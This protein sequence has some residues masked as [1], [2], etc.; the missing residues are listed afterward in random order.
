MTKKVDIKTIRFMLH[1]AL[2]A[3]RIAVRRELDRIN[4]RSGETWPEEKVQKKLASLQK[5]L[6]KS[7][8]KRV[9][10]EK[11]LPKLTYNPDL[12]IT[13]KKEEII[14][15]I[16]K[17]RV[18]IISGE[19]GSGKTTQIPKFCLSAG[20]GIDGIIGCTQPRR[21]AATTVAARIAEELESLLG[22]AVGYKIRFRDRT[23]KR[24]YIKLMTDGILLTEAQADRRLNLYDTIIVDEAH[25]RSLNIDFILGLLRTLIRKRKDLKVIITSATI[26]T[27]KFS[28]AFDSA[29]VIE[30]SG[31]MYPVD[32]R[33]F[34]PEQKSEQS[35]DSTYI[36][37]AI[38]A[39]DKVMKEGRT[40][41]ILV[42]MPTEQDIRET[43]DLIEGRAYKGTVVFPLFARLSSAQQSRV[44]SNLPGRK[45]IVSTNIAETSITIPGI[46]YVI[47]TGLARISRYTP[48]SRTTSL[49][50]TAISRSS[51][52]QRMGR[53]GRVE[54]GVCIRLYSEDDYL[55]RPIFTPPEVLRAN[56]AEVILRMIAL[57]LGDVA[58]FPFIDRPPQ[59]SIADGFNLLTELGSI[60]PTPGKKG[61][62]KGVLF[63]LSEKGKL[64]ARM[65][66]DPRLSRM[67]IEARQ[68][69]CVDEILII[70]SALSIRDPRERPAERTKEADEAHKT[71]EDPLS[72]FI[73]L[74]NIWKRY[75]TIRKMEKKTRRIKKFCISH[76]L[77]FRRM[78]E[79]VDLH[80][81]LSSIFNEYV[82]GMASGALSAGKNCKSEK[83][84]R[85]KSG[86]KKKK[87]SRQEIY[88]E[89]YSAMHRSV[90]SG[91]LSNIAMKKEKNLF[92]STKGR[93]V[94][95]FPGSALFNKAGNWIVAAEMVE[96]S[97][98][99]ARIVADI[100]S[101]WLES[102][103][104]DQCKY[105]YLHPHWEKNRGEVIASEQVSLYGL[106]IVPERPVSYGRINPDEASEIFIREGLVPGDMKEKFPFLDH[107]LALVGN[108][109]DSEDRIRKRDIL[110]SDEEMFLFYRDRLDKVFDVRTLARVLRKKGKDA[111][112]WMKKDDLMRY[113]PDQEELSLYPGTVDLGGKNYAC[114]YVFNPEK[115]D[116]G[117]TISIPAPDASTVPIDSVD[118][119]VPGLYREKITALIK[120][121]PKKYRKKLVPVA[122]TVRVILDEMPKEKKS[123]LTSLNDFIYRRFGVDVPASEWP[124]ELLPDYLK[125]RVLITDTNGKEL[126]SSR[127][128]NMLRNKV[129]TNTGSKE[130]DAAKKEW[131]R[132]HITSWDMN[133][134]PDAI[135][136]KTV[137]G[138]EWSVYPGLVAQANHADLHLFRNRAEALQSHKKG[139]ARIYSIV[140]LKDLKFLRKS[141][142]LPQKSISMPAGFGTAKG[143]ENQLYESIVTSLY[144]I[145]I[146]DED[147]FEQHGESAKQEMMERGRRLL[148]FSLDILAEYNKTMSVLAGLG[149]SPAGSGLAGALTT[150]LKRLVPAN[151]LELYNEKK[152]THIT[153]Y[154]KAIGIR[155]RKA[156]VDFEKDRERQK[157][158]MVYS[159]ALKEL[160]EGLSASTSDEKR[161]AVEDFF[162]MI[163]EY[164]VSL[165]AQELKTA[166]PVSKK[167]LDKRLGEMKR[168]L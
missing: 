120:G 14:D 168:M 116:D 87:P 154:L 38:Q 106:I 43:C 91:F 51:A 13:A 53:C 86:K 4:T 102:L 45:I 25:E 73:T 28:K 22:E 56:L 100:D 74:L 40:G 32:V 29:P 8:R 60:V 57:K 140:F 64:M 138:K 46:K 153:R 128:K 18:V 151:F 47:D 97:R 15:A 105:S 49:P 58:E 2:R 101:N 80:T 146:R 161:K 55:V 166:V 134:I 152:F 165:F 124:E 159:S 37:R 89:R 27:E 98:L 24:P 21:I 9:Q 126:V 17:H 23:G 117:L 136:L 68:E 113:D 108:I 103:A 160:I 144:C 129:F 112:L 148:A 54:N 71:F 157:A 12:P 135:S 122:E 44:F 69:E 118:W 133:R 52:D 61:S 90:L 48:I 167:R 34:V 42:F 10:R 99:F 158:V 63:S 130:F 125:A 67:L 137:T 92:H 121:L 3:D 33:Y 36:E 93:E 115:P 150:E 11:N 131:E 79:W 143:F 119:L 110:V 20:R 75:N 59:K 81:Q 95:V 72:D 88:S 85:S 19:T 30:V 155:A 109:R 16:L 111:F 114:R 5:R 78:R 31:R 77:S 7:I 145:N 65:P 164:K 26:D 66:L 162:W 82:K 132:T 163:E 96:T 123:L 149:K 156:S 104:G 6:N 139:V 39:I 41:D 94:M 76:F 127:D 84:A 142:A 1:K 147:T 62:A 83:Q 50:V 70:A 141:I 35:D 107:N